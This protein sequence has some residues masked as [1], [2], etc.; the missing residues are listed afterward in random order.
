VWVPGAKDAAMRSGGTILS[1]VCAVLAQISGGV[2]ASESIASGAEK[3][4]VATPVA[5]VCTVTGL[6]K[7]RNGFTDTAVCQRF[8]ARIGE[9]LASPVQRAD[10][11]PAG[12][13][14]RWVKLEIKLKPRGRTEAELTS[15][16]HGK[17]TSHPLMAVQVMDKPVDLGDIDRLARL[18]GKTLASHHE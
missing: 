3:P 8:S 15:R 5:L 14:A 11:V 13:K 18:A 1:A 7:D 2:M 10:Q 17:A 6:P 16:L 4:S 12:N 9:A